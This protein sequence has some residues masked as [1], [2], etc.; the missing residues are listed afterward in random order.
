MYVLIYISRLRNNAMFSVKLGKGE[1]IW[2][3]L[4]HNNPSHI[5]DESNG[6]IAC[7]SYYK[8][9][10]DVQLLKDLGVSFYR[11]SLSWSR[12][13]PTG[14]PN[15]INQDG[16]QYYNNLINELL[17]NDIEPMVTIFHWDLPQ[18]LQEIGG[19]PN[20]VLARHFVNFAKI[21]FENFGDRVKK[22]ITINEPMQICKMGYGDNNL[23]P[24]YSSSGM[25]DYMC[26]YTVT[27][28]HTL[29][30]RLYKDSFKETQKGKTTF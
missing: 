22:W 27:R 1:N 30:Y 25:A 4:T 6:D 18:P 3:Y 29:A 10:E 7:N 21:V 16:I 28:A 2:D 14:Y 23:A 15:Y 5:V 26:T 12:I 24:A 20:P 13:L 8:Y 11:F 9:K 19:W 17:A